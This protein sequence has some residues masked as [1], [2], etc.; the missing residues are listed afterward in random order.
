MR[1]LRG[2]WSNHGLKA[3]LILNGVIE[4]VQRCFLG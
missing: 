1:C 3:T 4:G 2:S